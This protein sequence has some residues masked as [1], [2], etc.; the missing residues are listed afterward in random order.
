MRSELGRKQYLSLPVF[1]HCSS[2]V[3]SLVTTSLL[4]VFVILAWYSTWTLMDWAGELVMVSSSKMLNII[5]SLGLGLVPGLLAFSL[6]LPLLYYLRLLEKIF[7]FSRNN[8]E[9]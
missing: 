8:L 6:Q 5:L 2:P 4:E 3:L 7:S 9:F 1:N